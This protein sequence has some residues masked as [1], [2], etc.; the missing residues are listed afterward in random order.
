MKM[1]PM[2]A[3]SYEANDEATEFTFTLREG[4]SF[5]DGTPWN[6]DAAIANFEKW[7]DKDLG[8]KRTTLLCNVLDHFEKIDDY[9]VKVYLSEPFGAFV[10]TL[11]H[12][13]CVMMS[14]AQIAAGPQVCAEDP[15]GTGQYTFGEWVPGD[16]LT[17]ELNKDWWGYDA[18]IC[19]GTALADSD[20][21]FKSVTFKPVAEDATRMAMIQ[22]GDAQIVWPAPTESVEMLKQ[23]PNVTVESSESITVWFMTLNTQK[24][25]LNDVRVRQAMNYAINKD[26]Y[27]QVVMNGLGSIATSC[28]GP[29][30]QHYKGNDP[31]PYDVEKAKQLLAEA[32]YPDGFTTTLSYSNT[33]ANQKKAEFYK[34]QFAEVGINLELNGMENAVLNEQ[35]QGATGPGSDVMVECYLTGW[36]TSTGDADWGIRPLLAKESEPPLSY[37]MCYY[38]NEEFDQ[39]LVDA[40]QTA[41]EEK[42][43]E[44]YAKAQDMMW[45]DVP[46]ICV[47]NDFN[48]WITSSKVTGVKLYPD[49]ALNMKNAKM[50][51]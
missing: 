14:P 35:I 39:L 15:V 36:S 33:S 41:D 26:A 11:A 40:L 7:A 16:H 2:L 12:P 49:Q 34:Q 5:S 10:A 47:A 45:E 46:M 30:V 6:A 31:Y 20:A 38:E 18:D 44:C 1:Y 23:D 42:R 50:F 8:L 22:S 28:M 19:G 25:P 17:L 24:P 37:N 51:K 27:I 9:N 48:S 3:A 4:I 43:A 21:G 29:A 32:G 13:A